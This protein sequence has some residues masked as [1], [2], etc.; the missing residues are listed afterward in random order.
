MTLSLPESLAAM[1]Q[2]P[3]LMQGV[4]ALV[5][6]LDGKKMI[7]KNWTDARQYAEALTM[8]AVARGDYVAMMHD[9]WDAV[10]DGAAQLGTIEEDPSDYPPSEVWENQELGKTV[11]LATPLE[12]AAKLTLYISYRLEARNIR[13]EIAALDRQDNQVPVPECLAEL[14]GWAL[15]DEYEWD[16]PLLFTNSRPAEDFPVSVEE[17]AGLARQ[18][19]DAVNRIR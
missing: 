14:D 5:A 6:K 9:L 13:L 10:F 15:N 2:D 17:G 19:F 8:A 18:L 4:F 7:A 3:T 12:R 16:H 11:R 1:H